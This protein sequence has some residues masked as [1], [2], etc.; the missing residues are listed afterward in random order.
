MVRIRRGV[1]GLLVAGAIVGITTGCTASVPPE[2]V[3]PTF[4]GP[5]SVQVL[6][7]GVP[8]DQSLPD[9]FIEA[10]YQ[11]ADVRVE[12]TPL[13]EG[14]ILEIAKTGKVTESTSDFTKIDALLG[15]DGEIAKVAS[16]SDIESVRYGEDD[17]CTLADLSWYSANKV[18]LP[19]SAEEATG[20]GVIQGSFLLQVRSMN[21][22]G[23]ESR[24]QVVAGSCTPIARYLIPLPVDNPRS[25]DSTLTD[26]LGDYLI[27]PDG[28]SAIAASGLA[29][30]SGSASGTTIEVELPLAPGPITVQRP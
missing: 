25:S 12:W 23:T 30:P 19:T 27:S 29:F 22:I 15:V 4:P 21:N 2:G 14:Q 10:I 9:E 20:D 3:S 18:P 16:E 11:Q 5:D 8:E 13:T 17:S 6:T 24:W 28:Q 1:L 26:E 7:V